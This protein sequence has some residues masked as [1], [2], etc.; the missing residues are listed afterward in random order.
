MWLCGGMGTYL[1]GGLL[2]VGGRGL[3]IL[4]LFLVWLVVP[5]RGVVI[6]VGADAQ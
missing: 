1:A 4:L 5:G 3:G 6:L 2:M